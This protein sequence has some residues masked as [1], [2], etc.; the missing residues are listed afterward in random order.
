MTTVRYKG[1]RVAFVG[2]YGNG[3]TTLTTRLAQTTGLPR[4]HGS[5]M[6]DPLGASG[7]SLEDCGEAELLQLTVRRFTERRVG[8]AL[9]PRG[10]LSDG[11]VLHEWVYATVRLAL[12]RFPDGHACLAAVRRSG[13]RTAFEEVAHQL[14]QLALCHAQENYDLVVHLPVEVPLADR[15]SPISEAFREISDRLLLDE[16]SRADIPVHVV[17]GGH[18]ERLQECR[19]LIAACVPPERGLR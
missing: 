19:R 9:L 6:R 13:T 4:T 2:A 12:G 3:K 7:K 14:G 16:L 1:P 8:E 10:F 18:E 11:S 15:P 17:A 5:A